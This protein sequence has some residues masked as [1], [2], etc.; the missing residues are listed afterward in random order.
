MILHNKK[1]SLRRRFESRSEYTM[2]EK[3]DMRF[4]TYCSSVLGLSLNAIMSSSVITSITRGFLSYMER[5]LDICDL[6]DTCESARRYMSVAN[7][8]GFI[9]GD[10]SEGESLFRDTVGILTRHFARLSGGAF[11]VRGGRNSKLGMYPTN[12]S[13]SVNLNNDEGTT[14]WADSI[15]IPLDLC[16]EERGPLKLRSEAQLETLIR[17]TIQEEITRV[18]DEWD[19]ARYEISRD[20]RSEFERR[21][22]RSSRIRRKRN[23]G[24][25]PQDW[26][27]YFGDYKKYALVSDK[28]VNDWKSCSTSIRKEAGVASKTGYNGKDLFGNKDSV[29]TSVDK[30][31]DFVDRMDEAFTNDVSPTFWDL[32]K[33]SDIARAE[34]IARGYDYI[35]KNLESL[36]YEMTQLE[37]VIHTLYDDDLDV[38]WK[39]PGDSWSFE[40]LRDYL[41]GLNDQFV[42]VDNDDAVVFLKSFEK[43]A[44]LL[45]DLVDFE[46]AAIS[47]THNSLIW[48]VLG[49]S[50]RKVGIGI[51][52]EG[53]FIPAESRNR[54]RRVRK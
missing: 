51:P 3:L 15:S 9:S 6:G 49:R 20:L 36:V 39:M 38:N 26:E 33:S 11:Q 5:I 14:V 22:C 2:T 48:D 45:D 12:I 52:G 40:V 28:I 25:E 43:L 31:L 1:T 7:I 37:K 42:F 35:A 41:N 4:Q 24:A 46:N 30:V 47:D 18:S 8:R 29:Q 17:D 10:S 50:K 54:F 32:E 13:L 16:F 27:Q 44:Q 19:D 34:Q 23:E 53:K 21:K